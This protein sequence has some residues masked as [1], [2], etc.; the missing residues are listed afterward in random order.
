MF[1]LEWNILVNKFVYFFM[2]AV[3]VFNLCVVTSWTM[4]PTSFTLSFVALTHSQ[5]SVF[6]E[7]NRR[8]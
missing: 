2:E 6:T 4:I 5:L 3:N 7:Q 8:I 1:D